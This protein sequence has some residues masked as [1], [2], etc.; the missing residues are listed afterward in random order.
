MVFDRRANNA[1]LRRKRSV[2]GDRWWIYDFHREIY[3][4]NEWPDHVSTHLQVCT[5][6]WYRGNFFSRT[7]ISKISVVLI[8]CIAYTVT[9]KQSFTDE[10]F[11]AQHGLG[12]AAIAVEPVRHRP[13]HNKYRVSTTGGHFET[14][15]VFHR[16]VVK[17]KNCFW[18][19][20]NRL[21]K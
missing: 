18:G 5:F 17:K 9:R 12:I 6:V 13:L 21:T 3:A 7:Y 19:W 4:E 15:T 1:L 14:S 11:G 20:K 10:T 8:M 2:E 16:K